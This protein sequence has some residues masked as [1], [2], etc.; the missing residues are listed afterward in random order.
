MAGQNWHQAAAGVMVYRPRVDVEYQVSVKKE[1]DIQDHLNETYAGEDEEVKPPTSLPSL[2]RG[3]S[4]Q[5]DVMNRVRCSRDDSPDTLAADSGDED[6]V[7][8]PT[9]SHESMSPVV[10]NDTFLDELM[11]YAGSSNHEHVSNSP[12]VLTPST[13]S[14]EFEDEYEYESDRTDFLETTKSPCPSHVKRSSRGQS[15]TKSTRFKS[16]KMP[17]QHLP[18]AR[19]L[20]FSAAINSSKVSKRPSPSRYKSDPTSF[21][22]ALRNIEHGP[23]HMWTDIERLLLCII[24]RWYETSDNT[25]IAAVFNQV[26]GLDFKPRKITAQFT[27]MLGNGSKGSIH[28]A[29]VFDEVAFDDAKGVYAEIR[30]LIEVTAVNLHVQL[31]PRDE[32]FD[33]QSGSA[34]KAKSP[35]TRTKHRRRVKLVQEEKKAL[36]RQMALM[37]ASAMHVQPSNSGPGV[38]EDHF[39]EYFTDVEDNPVTDLPCMPYSGTSNNPAAYSGRTSSSSPCL[40]FRVWDAKSYTQFTEDGDFISNAAFSVK[41]KSFLTPFAPEGQGLSTFLFFA[42]SHLSLKGNTSAFVSVSTSL[43]Q[44][45]VYASSMENPNIAIIDLNHPSLNQPNKKHYAADVVR[46]LKVNDEYKFTYKA[47]AE[48]LIWGGIPRSAIL[49]HTKLQTLENLAEIDSVC[50]NMLSLG[51]FQTKRTANGVASILRDNNTVLDGSTAKSMGKIAKCLGLD[52]ESV[53]LQHIQEFVA[54]L[55]DGWYITSDHTN[56]AYTGNA[57]AFSFALALGSGIHAHQRVMEAF[58]EGIESGFNSIVRYA[59]SRRSKPRRNRTV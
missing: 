40:A 9:S 44:A 11:V 37:E 34:A 22:N 55:V 20:D 27:S 59:R 14:T 23:R 48:Y 25:A 18:V 3:C 16:K 1:S 45:M 53:T 52:G 24:H 10:T 49:H 47:T 29:Q 6:G 15:G 32:E 58:Q 38:I 54:R 33:F 19:R 43:L 7:L 2:N 57:I 35:G 13:Q 56:D 17:K 12:T 41:N 5:L 50:G 31:I 21:R 4:A 51:L 28:W 26:T 36:I 42:K 39:D 46:W 30:N 8:T